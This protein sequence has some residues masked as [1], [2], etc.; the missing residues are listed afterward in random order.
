MDKKKSVFDR[1]FKTRAE[2]LSVEYREM[3]GLK[4]WEPLDAFNLAKYLSIPVITPN[5]VFESQADTDKLCGTATAQS[6]WSALIMVT[7]FGERIII[8]NSAHSP[9]RQQSNIMH[10]MA[11]ILCAHEIPEKYKKM[12]LPSS[13]VYNDKK[14]E[15]E[16]AF[17]GS[18]LQLSRACLHWA[19]KRNMTHA[20]IAVHFL[21][22]EEM[23][24][25]RINASG[26][27]YQ[28]KFIL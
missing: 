3:L 15:A 26:V 21:A 6:E 10:E 24:R 7:F 13:L 19:L 16:A 12:A 23:V 5:E 9:A 22:S 8:H 2:K 20:E 14:Q 4:A 28:R 25:F 18:A 1:G 27:A 11:H 17:L